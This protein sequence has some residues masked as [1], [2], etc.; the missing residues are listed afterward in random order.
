MRKIGDRKNL[1]AAI[2]AAMYVP[3][4]LTV[5]SREQTAAQQGT[6][7]ADFGITPE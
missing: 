6:S 2:L 7:R 3:F 5:C 4:F 1:F